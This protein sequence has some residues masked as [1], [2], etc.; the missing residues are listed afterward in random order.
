MD[1]NFDNHPYLSRVQQPDC[2]GLK[3]LLG[4]QRPPRPD[5][6]LEKPSKTKTTCS[7]RHIQGLPRL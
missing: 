4:K 1:H 6:E 5:S 2:R 7:Y 3:P